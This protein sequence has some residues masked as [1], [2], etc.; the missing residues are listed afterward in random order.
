VLVVLLFAAEFVEPLFESPICA[1]PTLPIHVP[2]QEPPRPTEPLPD[3]AARY[4]AAAQIII[5]VR[6]FKVKAAAPAERY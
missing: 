2:A 1:A 5:H 6:S 3:V 4:D